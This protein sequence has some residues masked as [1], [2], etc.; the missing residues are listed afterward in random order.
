M[1]FPTPL[2]VNLI[3][4]KNSC[5][6]LLICALI[7]LSSCNVCRYSVIKGWEIDTVSETMKNQK[8]GLELSFKMREGWIVDSEFF[9]YPTDS[10]KT[11]DKVCA[12]KYTQE[13]LN[14]V[15]FDFERDS[16]C[17]EIRRWVIC[18][19]TDRYD[20]KRANRLIDLSHFGR[21]GRPCQYGESAISP[22]AAE[23]KKGVI[24]Q[25]IYCSEKEKRYI[26]QDFIPWNGRFISFVYPIQSKTKKNRD[27]DPCVW[28]TMGDVTKPTNIVGTANLLEQCRNLSI[29]NAMRIVT[30]P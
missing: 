29:K 19:I 11:Q 18:Y 30:M 10:L 21:D 5:Y 14:E 15:G 13:I 23:V 25:Q 6:V 4:M 27:L 24:Y 1:F 22:K 17:Y 26:V 3:Y 9:F 8:L 7:G 12:D 20:P 2:H 28:I 16:I